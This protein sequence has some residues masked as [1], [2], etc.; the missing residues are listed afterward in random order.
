MNPIFGSAPIV[1]VF[2]ASEDIPADSKSA[3]K[4]C[5][6]DQL[7]AVGPPGAAHAVMTSWATRTDAEVSA[8]VS[9]AAS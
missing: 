8:V 1:I 7:S 2:C 6:P 3:A 4:P 9:M 5:T